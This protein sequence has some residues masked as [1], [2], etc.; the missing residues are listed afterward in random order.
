MQNKNSG[1]HAAFFADCEDLKHLS[2]SSDSDNTYDNPDD[3]EA[4]ISISYLMN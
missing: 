1:N 2:N 4:I 3:R